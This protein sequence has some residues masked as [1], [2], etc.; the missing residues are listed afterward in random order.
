MAYADRNR[1]NQK[2]TGWVIAGGLTVL[3]L[4]GLI[5]ALN[6]KGKS[7]HH[8]NMLTEDVKEEKKEEKKPDA[9]KPKEVKLPPPPPIK[10]VP[11]IVQV[12]SVVQTPP[13]PPV[14]VPP[15][16][17]PVEIKKPEPEAPKP[18]PAEF[19]SGEITDE[20]YPDAANRNRE[21]G[22]SVAHFTIGTDGRVS[23]C[24]ASGATSSLNEATCRL[25]R[26]RFRYRPATQSGTPVSSQG[27]RRVT[28]RLP[29]DN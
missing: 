12:K 14:N 22:T 20:D 19:K 24:S 3:L 18:T 5:A 7:G 15:P 23:D 27:T 13:P 10:I 29:A 25:I 6:F 11:P 17:P 1:T 2:V 21:S 16:P 9:P 8:K 26:Q 4:A 28:W